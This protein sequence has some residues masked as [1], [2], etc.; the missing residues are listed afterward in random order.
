MK[1]TKNMTPTQETLRAAMLSRR[2]LLK[3]AAAIGAAG[4]AGPLYV[5]NAYSIVG[6]TQLTYVVG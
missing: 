2:S 3:S 4:L 1:K 5:K 6:R